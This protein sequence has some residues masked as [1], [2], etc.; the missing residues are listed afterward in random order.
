MY[1]LRDA[2]AT[3]EA[4]P[5]IVAS[6]ISKKGAAGLEAMVMDVKVGSGAFMREEERARSLAEALV[7]TGNACGIR[8]RALL[9][10]MNQPLGCA[11]G[12]SIE[13]RE[14]IG[15][16]RGEFAPGARP[17]LDLSMELSAHILVLAHVDDS[18][19]EAR[20]RLQRALESGEAL[21]RFRQNVLAQGGDPRV[22]DDPPGVLPLVSES[23]TVES[24]R[25]GYITSVETTEIGH[26]IAALGGGRVRIDDKIDASVGFMSEVKI[27]D[28]ITA[29]QTLGV[30]YS[31]D[32][33]KALKAVNRIQ[34]AFQ[35]GDEFKGDLPTLIKE[36]I[37]E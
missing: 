16:L 36:V 24:R 33:S 10:D 15:I 32:E 6:I 4:I 34:A 2:T 18:L 5:L 11:V 23:F 30:V 27:G 9:T 31:R 35:I 28:Q 20:Q 7:K 17:V 1:A 25:P 13:V 12:N 21:E 19:D 37:N 22:C 29:G 26:A 3:V 14:C 8:T